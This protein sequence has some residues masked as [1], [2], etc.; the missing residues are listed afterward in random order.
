MRSLRLR[1]VVVGRD[2]ENEAGIV[3]K[4]PRPVAAEAICVGRGAVRVTTRRSRDQD[5][6]KHFQL[7]NSNNHLLF[8]LIM[9]P[10][11][12]F[13]WTKSGFMEEKWDILLSILRLKCGEKSLPN[14]IPGVSS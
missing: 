12:S 14:K 11:K 1:D 10:I 13:F 4:N 9:F 6:H 2:E 5:R 7:S 8:L 3:L